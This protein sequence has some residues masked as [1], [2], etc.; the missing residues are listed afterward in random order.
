[1]DYSKAKAFC[2]ITLTSFLFKEMEKVVL[3]HLEVASKVHDRLSVNQ[4]ALHKGSSCVLDMVD[5]I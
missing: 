5:E 3:K 1:M 2:P 4:P